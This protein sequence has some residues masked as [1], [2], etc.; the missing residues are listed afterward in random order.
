MKLRTIKV[1]GDSANA[2]RGSFRH[3]EISIRQIKPDSR[4]ARTHSAKQ[5]RQIANSIVAFGFTNPLLVSE[6]CELIA[7]FG[8]YE[9]I[10][11]NKI[12]QNSRCR[13]ANSGISIAKAKN[14]DVR[15]SNSDSRKCRSS[16]LS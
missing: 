5:I 1:L 16:I 15:Q 4:N 8:R 7:G 11:D 9:A 6:D 2:P 14:G 3:D 10:A 13:S 12:A